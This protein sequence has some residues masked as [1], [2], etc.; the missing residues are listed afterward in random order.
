MQPMP[1]MGL[2]KHLIRIIFLHIILP[3]LIGISIYAF[4]RGIPLIDRHNNLFPLINS[5]SVPNWLKYNLPDGLWFYAFLFSIFLIW[6]EKL[7]IHFVFWLLL[8]I[9][10]AC[11]SEILQ[12]YNLIPGTFDWYDLLA[13]FIAISVFLL[14]FKL[15]RKRLLFTLNIIKQ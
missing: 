15:T 1:N 3:I 14:N 8:V 2:N 10:M 5:V 13:Y 12:A 11:F 9:I 6:K 4:F 7:S